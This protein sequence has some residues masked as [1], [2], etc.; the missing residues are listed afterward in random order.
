MYPKVEYSSAVSK[1]GFLNCT[2]TIS[3]FQDKE[4]IKKKEF[5]AGNVM[6]Y[7]LTFVIY[8]SFCLC[9]EIELLI[10]YQLCFKSIAR[11]KL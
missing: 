9:P 3:C 1:S 6:S 2:S 8:R 4:Q 5:V 11:L 10:R 7:G